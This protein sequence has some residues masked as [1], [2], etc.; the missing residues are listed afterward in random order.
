[1]LPQQASGYQECASAGMAETS[2]ATISNAASGHVAAP[3]ISVM[4]ARRFT[5]QCSRGF[6]RKDSTLSVAADHC[7][8]G[9]QSGLCRL[10][11]GNHA[12][13]DALD[14]PFI[15]RVSLYFRTA[16]HHGGN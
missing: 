7:A 13:I 16:D 9:F 8:A 1:M 2:A 3:P 11:V 14:L 15:A 12:P 6:G 10:W 5:A 4:N